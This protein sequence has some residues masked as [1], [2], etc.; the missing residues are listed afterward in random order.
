MQKKKIVFI[1]NIIFMSKQNIPWNQ[2]EQYLKRYI[3]E[4]YQVDTYC[5]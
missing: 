2:V 1:E 4:E 3:G 5:R